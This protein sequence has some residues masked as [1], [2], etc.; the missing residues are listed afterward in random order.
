MQTQIA[1]TATEPGV[2]EAALR[3][4]MFSVDRTTRLVRQLLV[5]ARLD[6]ERDVSLTSVRIGDV[7]REMLDAL[8]AADREADV[9]VDPILQTTVV[10][11]SHDALL[12]AVRNL[13]ENAVRHMPQLGVIR[14]SQERTAEGL[15]LVVEDTGRGIAEAELE[16]VTRR[17]FRGRNKT[18]LGSGLGLSI[19]MLALRA[20]GARLRLLNRPDMSGLRAE[21]LWP[22]SRPSAPPAKGQSEVHGPASAS[23]PLPSLT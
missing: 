4:I 10:Q 1:M 20:G 12:L 3:Q 13:H 19:V 5:I 18:T 9:I 11:T 16:L 17:F 6:S 23:Q 7:L 2:R 8:P 21:I 15:V 22:L 14:W